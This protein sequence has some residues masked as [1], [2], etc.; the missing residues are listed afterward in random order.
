MNILHKEL[1]DELIEFE[2][3][4]SQKN[5]LPTQLKNWEF[6]Y[7]FLSENFLPGIKK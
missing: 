2:K 6:N 3:Q 7:P 5:T 4:F 1:I